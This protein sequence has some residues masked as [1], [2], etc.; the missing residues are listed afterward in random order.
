MI[1]SGTGLIADA[2]SDEAPWSSKLVRRWDWQERCCGVFIEILGGL[3][4]VAKE[5]LIGGNNGC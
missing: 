2:I 4:T 1:L 5:G 3:G